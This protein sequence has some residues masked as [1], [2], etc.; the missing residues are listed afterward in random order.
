MK[1][2][3]VAIVG[4]LDTKGQEYKYLNEKIEENDVKTIMI[5]VGVFGPTCFLPDIT[6][7]EV[8][9]AGGV[10]LKSIVKE[11]DRGKAVDV[12]SRGAAVIVKE[13]YDQG[14][15]DGIIS[16]GGGNGTTIGTTAMKALPIGVPKLMVSTIA[17]GDTR[18]Y[19]DVADIIMM[20]SIVDIEGINRFS[21]RI[22]INAAG[23]ITGM[24]KPSITVNAEDKPLIAA[25]MYGVT[26]P[27]VTKAKRVLE[28]Y[29][30]EVLVFHTVGTG[31]RSMEE[32]IKA[33]YISGVLDI[34]TTELADEIAGGDL[35]AGPKRLEASG[36]A[37]VPQVVSAGAIDMVNFGVFDQ[38]PEKYHNRNLYK[39]NPL[40]TLMRTSIEE[41]KMLG[42]IIAEKLN[43]S[44]G[45]TI[46]IMP[47]KGVSSLDI[48]GKPLHDPEANAIF[49]QTL[50]SNLK[51]HIK[52]VEMNTDINDER[53]AEKAA[54]LLIEILNH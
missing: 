15:I 14:K 22:L 28:N 24:V 23:A 9:N 36:D 1:K 10:E 7:E 42:K 32:L 54:N 41:N 4:A 37:G 39:Y 18:R 12:M 17:S 5:D 13:L 48:E 44:K 6:A 53:F 33:G 29:G 31:G 46:F 30:Y 20:P 38:I 8:A 49:L 45:P 3:V 34:T 40:N 21:K 35:S 25:T 43:H 27:C 51:Q 26:T 19:V 50:K 16:M 47:T 2:K 11:K 52:L